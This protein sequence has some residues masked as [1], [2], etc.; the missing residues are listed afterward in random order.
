[1]VI[2]ANSSDRGKETAKTQKKVIEQIAGKVEE[3]IKLFII[4]NEHFL[5]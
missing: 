1:M 3:D 4:F 5:L 2:R